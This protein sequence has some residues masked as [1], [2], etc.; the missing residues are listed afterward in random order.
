[1]H[2]NNSTPKYLIFIL[3]FV[4]IM[5][6]MATDM[7]LP[8]LPSITLYFNTTQNIAQIT[9]ASYMIG[10]AIMQFFYGPISDKYGRKFPLI[11]SILIFFL[12]SFL[13]V[14]SKNIETLIGLRFLQSLGGAAGLTISLAIIRDVYDSEKSSNMY[15][16]I[17]TMIAVGPAIAPIIGGALIEYGDWK[18]I[19]YALTAWALIAFIFITL[20]LPETNHNLNK[21]KFG[22]KFIIY[23]SREL[24]NSNEY[25]GYLLTLAFIFSAFFSFIFAA[26][27]IFINY[28][29]LSVSEFPFI[30]T[31]PVIGFIIG[32]SSVTTLTKKISKNKAFFYGIILAVFS[33]FL[34]SFL[35][36]IG[37]KSIISIIGPMTLFAFSVGIIFPIGTSNSLKPFPKIAGLASA[38]L[39]FT[40][41]IIGVTFGMLSGI[42]PDLPILNMTLLMT[43]SVFLGGTIY[44]YFFIFKKPKSGI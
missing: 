43:I 17:G 33:G 37:L 28:F 26:P 22:I 41:T 24:M 15:A 8:S 19:F 11:I 7:I 20:F 29:N 44:Y 32:T 9:L 18:W 38:F 23:N 10:F 3:G 1:M 30:I 6:E 39:G 13:S 34:I 42:N 27:F 2:S 21:N 4:L 14:F 5:G 16:K 36:I 12:G 40:Q 25:V 35:P 31:I